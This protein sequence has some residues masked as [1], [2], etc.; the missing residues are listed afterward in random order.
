[1]YRYIYMYAYICMYIYIYIYKYIYKYKYTG[2]CDKIIDNL[3]DP[4]E[5]VSYIP[6][7]S[8]SPLDGSMP[9]PI[10]FDSG[11][12]SGGEIQVFYQLV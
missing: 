1:M 12:T 4:Y 5:F 6:V 9:N 11:L 7:F 3:Y 2:V 8:Y 10:N